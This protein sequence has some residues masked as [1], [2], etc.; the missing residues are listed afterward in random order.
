MGNWSSQPFSETDAPFPLQNKLSLT[1]PLT[2]L[3]PTLLLHLLYPVS[4][5]SSKQNMKIALPLFE[6]T[7]L[8]S[9]YTFKELNVSYKN[10]YQ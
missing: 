3:A 8:Y 9:N 5:F 1:S 10:H 6:A 4:F 2:L 7:N